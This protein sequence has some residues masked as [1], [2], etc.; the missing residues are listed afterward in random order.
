MYD[1]SVVRLVD[2]DEISPLS[3]SLGPIVP[4]K[5]VYLVEL[6]SVTADK[7]IVTTDRAL[8]DQVH[9]RQGF[10]VLLLDEFLKSYLASGP[11]P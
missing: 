3:S 10:Q 1:P 7:T 8:H 5:D 9:G 2:E 6:A 11:G 4:R